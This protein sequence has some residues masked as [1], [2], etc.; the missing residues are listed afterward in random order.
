MPLTIFHLLKEQMDDTEQK[1]NVVNGDFAEKLLQKKASELTET[2]I[3]AAL[4]N[5]AQPTLDTTTAIANLALTVVQVQKDINTL[6]GMI[7]SLASNLNIIGEAHNQLAK[8]VDDLTA[9]KT[10]N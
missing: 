4:S 5:G 9:L 10:S 1:N 2:G 8:K 6:G 7:Q 3:K